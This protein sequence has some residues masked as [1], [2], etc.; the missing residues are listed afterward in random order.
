MKLSHTTHVLLTTALLLPVA[1][2]ARTEEKAASSDKT[3]QTAQAHFDMAK[4]YDAKAAEYKADA[5]AHKQMLAEYTQRNS[6]PNLQ[7]KLG[8]DPWIDRMKAHCESYIASAEA[9]AKEATAFA[10]YHR[11]RGKEMGG[12]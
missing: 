3:P 1:A 10:D 5:E 9:L 7:S 6:V 11:M 4:K 12:K 2:S 8:K